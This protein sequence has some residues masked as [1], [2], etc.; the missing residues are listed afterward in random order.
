M[1]KYL[2]VGLGNPGLEYES[3]R[4][5]VGF[6][7]LD[8]LGIKFDV[9]FNLHKHGLLGSFKL[10]GREI[11]LLK[12][13]TFMN[14]SGKSVRYHLNLINNKL[15]NLLVVADDLHLP[16]GVIKCRRKGSD[17]GHN[18][19]KDIIQAL[20]SSHYARLKFGIGNQFK[21]GMQSNYVLDNWSD[22]ENQDL[23]NLFM[24]SSNLI[25]TFC[26]MGIDE[27]MKQFN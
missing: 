24:K 11:F 26:L 22:N 9:D 17:G 7:I 23:T 14:A 3:T 13:N 5:N 6:E 10:K 18:G 25:T 2:I 8:Y 21:T 15:T 1:Q 16:F 27:T 20:N 12:P 19:H 4:H